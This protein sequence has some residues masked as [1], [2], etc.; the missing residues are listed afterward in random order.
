MGVQFD[1]VTMQQALEMGNRTSMM[2]AGSIILDVAGEQR[3]RM[4]VAD[5]LEQFA[6]QAGAQL[7]NDRILLS[8]MVEG[9][10]KPE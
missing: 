1:N 10:K 7:E 9:Q 4:T 5:L 8:T 6:K 3:V 2:N